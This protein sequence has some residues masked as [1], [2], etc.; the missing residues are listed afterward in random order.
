M[1][2][3]PAIDYSWPPREKIEK[4]VRVIDTL[5]IGEEDDNCEICQAIRAG[6]NPVH[7]I[8]EGVAKGLPNAFIIQVPK[9]P[10]GPCP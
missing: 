4:A 1:M 8:L 10:E 3:K 2:R 7:A 9:K 5:M 6:K